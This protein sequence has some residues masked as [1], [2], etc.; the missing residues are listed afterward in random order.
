M[1]ES[2]VFEYKKTKQWRYNKNSKTK[3]C[4]LL[5]GDEIDIIIPIY[6]KFKKGSLFNSAAIR[7]DNIFED[8]E[9]IVLEL[10]KIEFYDFILTNIL[11][12]QINEFIEFVEKNKFPDNVLLILKNLELNMKKE[13]NI[14]KLE[15]IVKINELSNVLAVSIL[16]RDKNQKYILVKRSNATIIGNEFYGVTATGS[17]DGEDFDSH[18]PLLNCAQRELK[19]ELNLNVNQCDMNIVGLVAG[20]NKLQPIAIIDVELNCEVE[21]ILENVSGA[22]D[23]TKEIN[24]IIIVSKEK[25]REV[26]YRGRYTEAA[27]Y[28]IMQ[29]IN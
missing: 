20:K 24:E 5:S 7:L 23:Y 1:N 11:L 16:V 21:S 28:H 12:M 26:I 29:H 17:V 9:D 8:G 25:L 14:N 3:F 27:E 18:N 6:K 2:K 15:D 13:R 19:E 4:R 22:K 10:S